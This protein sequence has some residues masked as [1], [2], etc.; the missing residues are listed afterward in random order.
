LIGELSAENTIA[1]TP[2]GFNIDIIKLG[3]IGTQH[4]D[5]YVDDVLK[6]VSLKRYL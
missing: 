1:L 5:Y 6:I 4:V 2:V 3:L